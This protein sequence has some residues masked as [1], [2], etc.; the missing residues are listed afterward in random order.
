MKEP[1]IKKHGVTIEIKPCPFCG[2]GAMLRERELSSSMITTKLE[3]EYIIECEICPAE[4]C[5]FDKEEVLEAW[6][7]RKGFGK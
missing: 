4:M 2:G 1:Y 7:A 5:L 6:D 3:L